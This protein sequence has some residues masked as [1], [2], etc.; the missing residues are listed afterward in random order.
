MN[1]SIR[2]AEY[3][4]AAGLF[5]YG[6]WTGLSVIDFQNASWQFVSCQIWLKRNEIKWNENGIKE[7]QMQEA[8][9]IEFKRLFTSDLNIEI[10]DKSK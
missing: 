1:L 7:S 9:T 4:K 8:S 3:H 2:G 10:D 6:K 5:Y